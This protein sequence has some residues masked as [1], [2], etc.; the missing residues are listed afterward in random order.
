MDHP[1]SQ[2]NDC[3]FDYLTS[4]PDMAKSFT[5]IYNDITGSTGHRCSELNDPSFRAL[6]KN[7]FITTC[8]TLDN[9]YKNIHKIFKS[10]TPYLV[11][12]SK[13]KADV[14]MQFNLQDLTDS[15]VMPSSCPV[16]YD[17]MIDYLLEN[18]DQ[19]D[20]FDFN[21]A[22]MTETETLL[23]YIIKT[24]KL[25]QFRKIMSLYD[26]DLKQQINGKSLIDFVLECGNVSLLKE[27]LEHQHNKNVTELS[28]SLSNVKKL[29]TRLSNNNR[30]LQLKNQT[31]E[32]TVMELKERS[33]YFGIG[34]LSLLVFNVIYFGSLIYKIF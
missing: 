19:F 1:I 29:N 11:F 9:E 8:Y 3:I 17:G 7:R 25:E 12:S 16:D 22:Q 32:G 2:L 21:N 33:K 13:P 24:N 27:L 6:R 28:T 15:D 23:Q 4:Y 18:T 20:D 26:I 34:L 10:G 31:L 30:I 5:Q 14:A